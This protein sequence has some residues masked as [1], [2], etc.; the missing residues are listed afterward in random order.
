MKDRTIERRT[1][2]DL[3]ADIESINDE[4]MLCLMHGDADTIAKSLSVMGWRKVGS[5]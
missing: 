1:A 2:K 5:P 4:E 3:L